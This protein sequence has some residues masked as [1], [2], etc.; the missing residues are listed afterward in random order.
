SG[1]PRSFSATANARAAFAALA[2]RPPRFLHGPGWDTVRVLC[3]G[4]DAP[5]PAIA[6]SID[7]IPL[8]IRI[9]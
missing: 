8:S 6:G 7:N 2:A 3:R 4:A 9:R 1:A 5:C